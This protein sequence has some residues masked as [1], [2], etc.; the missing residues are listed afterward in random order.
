MFR[1]MAAM[2]SARTV[3]EETRDRQVSA[4]QVAGYKA[5]LATDDFKVLGSSGNLLL[6]S[7]DDSSISDYFDKLRSH[8]I[9]VVR[10][11][12]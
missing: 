9:D 4:R 6:A 11:F 1:E 12:L 7:N 5:S 3:D 8:K 2:R 10:T